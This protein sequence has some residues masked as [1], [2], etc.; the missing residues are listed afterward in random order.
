MRKWLPN[1]HGAWAMLVAPVVAGAFAAGPD[2]RH[3]QL[4]A[5][6]LAAYCLNFYLGLTVKSWRRADRWRRYRSQQLFYGGLA[7]GLG[8]PLLWQMPELFWLAPLMLLAFAVNLFAIRRHQERAWLNDVTG[9][10]L[11][12]AMGAVAVYLVAGTVGLSELKMLLML[13]GYFA[14]TVWYVKTMIRE[15]GEAG[16]LALSVAWHALLIPIGWW[17]H[18]AY[19]AVFAV[20]TARSAVLPRRNLTAK[21]VGFVEIG[22]TLAMLAAAY[23]QLRG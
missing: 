19:A 22:F 1:Q 20:A 15:R 3:L 5:A 14:G 16:W 4:L 9:I 13:G 2:W 6:W 23:L 12:I 7:L 17:V 11:A 10:T 8:G 21:Q 18:P